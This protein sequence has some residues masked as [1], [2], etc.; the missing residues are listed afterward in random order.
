M[1]ADQSKNSEVEPVEP[2]YVEYMDGSK[3]LIGYRK[4]GETVEQWA[5]RQGQKLDEQFDEF[6]AWCTLKGVFE[7]P[8]SG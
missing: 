4:A 3:V 6:K 1:T 5:D 7:V 2:I 8:E